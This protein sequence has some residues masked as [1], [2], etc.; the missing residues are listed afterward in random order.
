MIMWTQVK[1][2]ETNF[3]LYKLQNWKKSKK[4]T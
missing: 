2:A 4:S 3:A 1:I